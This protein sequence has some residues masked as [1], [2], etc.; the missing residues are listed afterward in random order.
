[1]ENMIPIYNYSFESRF[2][3]CLI[4]FIFSYYYPSY[5][6]YQILSVRALD[7]EFLQSIDQFAIS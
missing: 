4:Q 2:S 6:W 7:D 3:L 5:I 1:M